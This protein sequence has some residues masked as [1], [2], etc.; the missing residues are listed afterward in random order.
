MKC[1]LK[2]P[3]KLTRFVLKEEAIEDVDLSA[4]ETRRLKS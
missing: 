2:C 1:C 4:D 3:R